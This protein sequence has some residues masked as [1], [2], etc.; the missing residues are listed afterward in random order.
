[1]FARRL[2]LWGAA[3]AMVV[4]SAYYSRRLPDRVASHFGADGAVDGWS[5]RHELVGIMLSVTALMLLLFEGLAWLVP[6]LPAE[7]IN[8]PNREYWLAP[9]RRDA[10]LARIRA[11]LLEIG[12]LTLLWLVVLNEL[13]LRT[14]LGPEPRLGAPFWISFGA[15]LGAV[16]WWAV[17]SY[18]RYSRI[19]T[20]ETPIVGL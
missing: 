13:V 8:L 15:Y 10:T 2:L 16:G 18:R 11:D 17:R 7:W 9:G 1:M 5:S 14:N 4:Q 12:A 3:L 6:R 19:P 20:A